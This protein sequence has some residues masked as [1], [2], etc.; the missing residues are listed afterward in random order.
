MSLIKRIVLLCLIVASWPK[1]YLRERYKS[2]LGPLGESVGVE[3][4]PFDVTADHESSRAANRAL[5][6]EYARDK[7]NF[8]DKTE[9]ILDP[10]LADL[11]PNDSTRDQGLNTVATYEERL[12]ILRNKI[13]M[14]SEPLDARGAPVKSKQRILDEIEVYKLERILKQ[15]VLDEIETRDA[16]HFQRLEQNKGKVV[17]AQLPP[18]HALAQSSWLGALF[19]SWYD[20]LF[21]VRTSRDLG[22]GEV[23]YGCELRDNAIYLVLYLFLLRRAYKFIKGILHPSKY[24]QSLYIDWFKRAPWYKPEI[25]R[26][27]FNETIMPTFKPPVDHTHGVDAAARS[28][29]SSFIDRFAKLMGLNAYYVQCSRSDERHGRQGSRDYYWAKDITTSPSPMSIPAQ[30]LVALVDVDQYMDMPTFL[31]DNVHPTIIYT[32]QPDQV[33]KVQPTYSYT[34]DE[35]D[36]LKYNVTGG[37]VFSHKVWNYGTDHIVATKTYYG[38]PYKVSSYL[39]DRKAAASDHQVIMLTPVGSW[40]LFGALMYSLWISGRTLQRLFVNTR[41]GFTRLMSSSSTGMTISTGRPN[42]YASATVSAVVDDTIASVARTS[43]YLLTLP[44]VMSYLDGDRIASLPLL[45]Y[46]RTKYSFKPDVVCPVQ[47]S[48]RRYQFDP[49]SFD[50]LAK[51]SLTGFMSPLVHGAFAPDKTL[52]NE[53][54]AIKGRITSVAPGH[55]ELTPFL[56]QAMDEFCA[57]LIPESEKHQLHPTD[58]DEVLTRQNKP[59]QRRTFANMHGMIPKRLVKMFQKSEAYANVKDPRAISI[60]DPVDKREYSRF[61]YAFEKVLKKQPWYAFSKTPRHVAARVAQILAD[62]ETAA[63]TDFNRFD[64]HGSNV[65]RDLERQVIMRAFHP[66]H[67]AVLLDLHRGQHNL[68]AYATFDSKYHTGFSRASGSPETSVFNT[69]VNAFVAFLARRMSKRDGLFIGPVEAYERLGIY[70]GDDGLTADIGQAKYIKA[71]TMIGQQLTIEPI[72]RGCAG[73]KFLARVYSPE[74]WFGNENS[75]CDVKRQ[76]VKFH[77]TVKLNTNVTPA[78]K[79]LEKARGFILSDPNTPIIGDFCQAVLR[80]HGSPILPND[81]TIPVRSWLSHYPADQQYSNERDQWMIDSVEQALPEFEYKRFVSWCENATTMK[82]LLAPPMFMGPIPAKSDIPVV[83]DEEVL[84]IGT[85]ITPA[86]SELKSRG[87]S[88]RFWNRRIEPDTKALPIK[89]S[90]VCVDVPEPEKK[91]QSFEELKKYKQSKGTWVERPETNKETF[92]DFKK[93]KIAEG[94]WVERPKPRREVESPS[95]HKLGY[96]PKPSVGGK[97]KFQLATTAPLKQVA[98]PVSP[99]TQVALMEPAGQRFNTTGWRKKS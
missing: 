10:P 74:V 99:E 57:Q 4:A 28:A 17:K 95:E 42:L 12:E 31:C 51:P 35:Q 33:S 47:H 39:V 34:F 45:E 71:A 37:A 53:T 48:V 85:T 88:K 36:I 70:G 40:W 77:T 94:K 86:E 15:R 72:K 9:P 13:S 16:A 20:Y 60:V 26:N 22:D 83:V 46:H 84:P 49:I 82:Q 5:R 23:C 25:V 11:P 24:T 69:L 98:R 76:L 32:V 19:Y 90:K 54:Q 75:T 64:G 14:G 29:A 1:D 6:A 87:V 50:P 55:I 61:M 66:R 44:Q 2:N 7:R 30:P 73:I 43:Q 18:A 52:G 63:N 58:D 80:V 59:T 38:I 65:M 56:I 68:K 93:R 97:G 79:L 78:M 41:T 62:A 96:I 8:L 21:P 92:E 27:A 81:P 89:E 67:H 3:P 91:T